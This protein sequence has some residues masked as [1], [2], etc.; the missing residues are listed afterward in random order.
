[1]ADVTAKAHASPADP[2]LA[3]VLVDVVLPCRDEAAALPDV[4][5]RMPHGYRAIVVDNGSV[6]GTAQVAIDHG[7]VV[8]REPV[9]GYG[10]AVHAGICAAT[11]DLVAVLDGDGSLDPAELPR[12]VAAITIGDA[13][14]VVGRRRPL[15]VGSW[16]WHARIGS[17]VTARRVRRRVGIDV[18]DIGPVRVARRADLLALDVQDRRFGYPV[19]LLMRAGLAGWRVVEIDV[20]YGPRAAGT[21]SK[22]SGSLLGTVRA[23][24]DF[25]SALR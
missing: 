1:M 10:S 17:R 7:A 20:S 25:A 15:R 4:L 6:D 24:R 14:L 9:S 21:R 12:L 11:A 23:A 8:V 18:H 22:V 19:E 13:D 16:P 3:A 2:D 5:S